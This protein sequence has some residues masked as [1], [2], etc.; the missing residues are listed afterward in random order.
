MFVVYHVRVMFECIYRYLMIFM[1]DTTKPW[2]NS[3]V[4]L[5]VSVCHN[6]WDIT[7]SVQGI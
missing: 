1:I 4:K 3:L 5:T 6:S 2:M 7:D